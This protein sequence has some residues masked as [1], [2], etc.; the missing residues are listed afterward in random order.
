V[1]ADYV[2]P[3]GPL[4]SWDA[5][6]IVAN[7]TG[8][9]LPTEAQGEYACRAETTTAYNTGATLSDNT[10]WYWENSDS[11][12]HSVGE[13]AAN[14]WNLY[15][16]HGNVFEWCWDWSAS[17]ASGAQTDPARNDQ[18]S[19]RIARG[20]SWFNAGFDL[21]SAHRD[22]GE[23]F[24][25]PYRRYN[26]LGFRLV[27]Q[28]APVVTIE[29]E[30][31]PGQTIHKRFGVSNLAE[32]NEARNE[33]SNGGNNKNYIITIIADFTI[34]GAESDLY[35]ATFSGSGIKVS[36]RGAGR[37]LTFTA[38][39]S[40]NLLRTNAGQTLIL[41]DLILKGHASNEDCVVYV[42]GSYSGTKGTFIME[43]GKIC[44]NW[45]GRY[46]GGVRV[47]GGGIFTMNGG[48]ISGN[49]A[50]Y[51]G[52]ESVYAGTF[53]MNAGTISGNSSRDGGGVYVDEEG[54]FEMHDGKI[55]GNI[56]N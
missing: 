13:K 43:S 47:E 41:R 4:K 28:L 17:Y 33:I 36:L 52:G 54:T 2:N 19:T 49:L 50:S 7:A 25:Y 42:A 31:F 51:G 46:G 22:F 48:E 39:G 37:T 23:S 34:V 15:D 27:R 11:R 29:D 14:A 53:T 16:M 21:R 9:R 20:G 3:F 8:Y 32:W 1:P 55:S 44:G 26:Y 10:G 5:V 18:Q 40:R 12:T 30:D 56:A 24:D 38:K 6:E 35:T 45:S